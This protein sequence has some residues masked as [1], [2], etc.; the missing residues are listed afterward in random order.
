MAEINPGDSVLEVEQRFFE[1]KW[2]ET[3]NGIVRL[4]G[5]RRHYHQRNYLEY[6]NL[7]KFVRLWNSTPPK[8]TEERVP[9]Q[10]G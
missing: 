3:D 8:E 7:I 4:D 6:Q 1:G 10:L 9:E 2:E 5:E